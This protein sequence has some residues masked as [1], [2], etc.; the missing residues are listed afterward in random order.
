MP[1]GLLLALWSPALLIPTAPTPPRSAAASLLPARCSLPRVAPG[2][3]RMAEEA[4]AGEEQVEAEVAAAPEAEVVAADDPKAAVD[5]EKKALRDQ[6]SALEKTLVDARGTLLAEQES[7]KDAGEG[8]YLLLAANFER[9]RQKARAELSNQ[10]AVGRVKAAGSLMTFVDEFEALQAEAATAA[11]PE[12]KIHSFY[13]GI[14]K[15]LRTLLTT[16]VMPKVRKYFADLLDAPR[17]LLQRHGVGTTFVDYFTSITCGHL[18]YNRAHS[19]NDLWITI[20]VALGDCEC[21]GGFVHPGCGVVQAVRAGDVLVVNPC[22]EHCTSEFGDELSSRRMV[23]IFVS[24]NA[25]RA[26]ATSVSVAESNALSVC[27]GKAKR[28]KR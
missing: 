18:F 20:L 24:E 17:E 21:G 25:F 27:Q 2:C 5:E 6:I 1:L 22:V 10:E 23:A 16:T 3:M 14:H 28:R 9:F 12:A 15:Q 11:E 13:G 4:E 8:G 19:D 7:V 26:C